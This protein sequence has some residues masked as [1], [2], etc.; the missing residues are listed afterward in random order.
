[1]QTDIVLSAQHLFIVYFQKFKALSFAKM[2]EEETAVVTGEVGQH[3]SLGRFKDIASDILND[4]MDN[5]QVLQIAQT[6]SINLS[7]ITSFSKKKSVLLKFVLEQILKSELANKSY[8]Q[9]LLEET[10]RTIGLRRESM[11]V[12]SLAGCLYTAEKHRSY[13]QHLKSFHHTHDKFICNFMHMCNRQFASLKALMDH[14]QDCHAKVGN[15]AEIQV[16][17]NTECRCDLLSCHG[18]KF[19]SVFLLMT[20]VN[21]VHARDERSCIFDECNVRF[22]AGSNS[23]NHFRIKHK[24]PGL[25]NL[26]KK[27]IV[28]PTP[29][30]ESADEEDT[31]NRSLATDPTE[32]DN[33]DSVVQEELYEENDLFE[34]NLTDSVEDRE[35]SKNYFVMQYADFLNRLTHFKFIPQK[36]VTEIANEFRLNSEKASEVREIKLRKALLKVPGILEE[37][38]NAIVQ[39]SVMDDEYLKA[40]AELNSEFKRKKYIQQNFK[41]INPVEIVLN[42]EEVKKGALKEVVHYIPIKESVKALLEDKGLNQVIEQERERFRQSDGVLRDFRDGSAFRES[43][44][45]KDNPGAYAAHFYSDGVELSNPLGAAKGRHKIVQMFYNLCQ[46]PRNQRSQIDRIQLCMVFKKK[47][48]K[49]HGYG[50]IFGALIEDLKDLEVG[51]TINYPTERRIQMGLLAFSA[52]NLEAHSIGKMNLK[53]VTP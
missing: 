34:D 26:K 21:T 31:G 17:Q 8:Y 53:L 36:N 30:E 39:E 37:Q 7:K 6:F 52:D 2:E 5:F 40:Q 1:M 44:F 24:L 16:V 10:V 49:K 14:L 42:K 32:P 47:L 15:E 43:P 48:V 23:R 3:D 4:V 38:I 28:S 12:C 20:H 18:I 29:T 27:N 19:K 50:A 46:I 45:F 25:M 41:Y 33:S 13:V 9:R 11:Y 51:M 35:Q 22:G